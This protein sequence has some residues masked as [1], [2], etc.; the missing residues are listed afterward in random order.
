MRI[1][2]PLLTTTVKPEGTLSKVFGG[3]SE[4]IH[5]SYAPYFIQRIRINATDPLVEVG[6]KLGW[7]ID[8]EVGQENLPAD[9]VTTKVI[10]FYIKSGA[11][12]PALTVSAKEQLDTYFMFQK[13]YTQ[14][15]SSN[16]IYVQPEEWNE[17]KETIYDKW[18]DFIG[19]TFLEGGNG[20]YALA[21]KEEITKEEYENHMKDYRPFSYNLF[22]SLTSEELDKDLEG[23]ESCSTGSCPII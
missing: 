8:P 20:K 10:S 17:M 4:G 3:V 23:M 11:T 9:K 6:E 16:T 14:H 12:K 7:K 22:K 18:D 21:P 5:R 13:E 19:V 2:M 15:N 1:P